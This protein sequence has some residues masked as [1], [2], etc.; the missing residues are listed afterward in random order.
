MFCSSCGK[1]NPDNSSFC[2]F[3]GA[4]VSVPRP[5]SPSMINLQK[6]QESAPSPAPTQQMQRKTVPPPDKPA[7][8]P[9][10]ANALR[11][12]GQADHKTKI[13]NV[14]AILV[15][16]CGLCFAL[17]YLLTNTLTLFRL[18]SVVK[19]RLEHADRF[20][21]RKGE[22]INHLLIKSGLVM[23][24]I[25]FAFRVLV[26]LASVIAFGTVFI[27]K[28][29]KVSIIVPV[30]TILT[31]I[32]YI[33]SFELFYGD[34]KAQLYH[35]SYYARFTG[36]LICLTEFAA[37]IGAAVLIIYIFSKSKIAGGIAAF[38]NTGALLITFINFVRIVF[39]LVSWAGDK[40][41]APS[42]LGGKPKPVKCPATAMSAF[43]Y[44]YGFSLSRELKGWTYN[45]L[46]MKLNLA[47]KDLAHSLDLVGFGAMFCVTGTLFAL[48]IALLCSKGMTKEKANKV[49]T[50][51][52][53]V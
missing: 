38:V 3:C 22:M 1:Q 14:I 16:V 6:P 12:G 11:E 30:F 23:T 39:K 17:Y 37:I 5:A 34:K 25:T 33:F 21:D 31:S 46:L 4:P 8:V 18:F 7:Y 20:P 48:S 27:G 19:V 40:Y 29:V 9:P 43:N 24:I 32:A 10:P 2:S 26:S 47:G 41:Q 15:A 28:G 52:C 51:A 36:H 53:S 35:S 42:S 45:T 50:G 49:H 44:F 13:Y